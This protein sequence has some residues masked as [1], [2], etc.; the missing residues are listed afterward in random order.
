MQAELLLREDV[1]EDSEGPEIPLM[2]RMSLPMAMEHAKKMING[3][4]GKL[5]NSGRK[6]MDDM[7]DGEEMVDGIK[8]G[9]NELDLSLSKYLIG[10]MFQLVQHFVY[11]CKCSDWVN[12]DVYCLEASK[13]HAPMVNPSML[14]C[15]SFKR[16]SFRPWVRTRSH[17]NVGFAGL[18][19]FGEFG[20]FQVPNFRYWHLCSAILGGRL[21]FN[22]WENQPKVKRLEP[23]N[24]ETQKGISFSRG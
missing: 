14:G 16:C 12:L 6:W 23:E 18:F 3:E 21:S 24:D 9:K 11:H 1:G 20:F 2:R 5:R 19:L 17:R 4:F 22:S 10:V 15:L 7:D 13:S 8:S